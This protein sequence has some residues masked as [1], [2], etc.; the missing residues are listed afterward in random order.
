VNSSP[1]LQPTAS[2][3]AVTTCRSTHTS[4]T[5]TATATTVPGIAYPI[6]ARRAEIRPGRVD[7]ARNP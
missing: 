2:L 3:A 7:R 4:G 6:V 5:Y 1:T